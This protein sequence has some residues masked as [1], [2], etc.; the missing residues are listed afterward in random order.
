MTAMSKRQRP[1]GCIEKSETA[2]TSTDTQEASRQGEGAANQ[3]N[4]PS[5][6]HG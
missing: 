4:G 1:G 3:E 2:S 5:L 6:A